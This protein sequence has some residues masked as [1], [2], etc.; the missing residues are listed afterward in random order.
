M[1]HN[2][3]ILPGDGVGPEVVAEAVKVLEC[4]RQE[5]GLDVTLEYGLLGGC[6]VDALGAPYPEETRRQARAADAILLGA[7]GGPKW[8]RLE[9]SLRPERG[10]LDLC[11][12]LELSF[13][14][15]PVIFH[16]QLAAA[17]GLLPSACLDANGKGLYRP[18][19][20]AIA[21]LAGR[22]VA[23]PL[24]AILAVAMLLRDTLN[25]PE[26]AERIERAVARV[27]DKGLR[28]MDIMAPGMIPVGTQ[29]MGDAVAAAL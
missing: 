14:P 1:V 9:Q 12:D 27:L 7:V 29:A 6:A 22:G 13:N 16:P 8:D 2:I 10:L 11:A 19:H 24:A 3:L 25:A 17:S 28:T 23:N 5:H 15:R 20:G 4:L 26:Q 18:G 21:D